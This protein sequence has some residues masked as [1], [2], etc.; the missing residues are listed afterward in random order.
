VSVDVVTEIEIA[1]RP[2]NAQL[3]IRRTDHAHFSEI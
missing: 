1:L 2:G 3:P